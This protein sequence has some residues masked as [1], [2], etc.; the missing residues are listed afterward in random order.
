MEWIK[1]DA[2]INFIY[3]SIA[4]QTSVAD[5][6]SFFTAPD[7]AFPVPDPAFFNL[8]TTCVN[9]FLLQL[10]NCL[11][12]MVDRNEDYLRLMPNRV[13]LKFKYTFTLSSNRLIL[14]LSFLHFHCFLRI[15]FVFWKRIRIQKAMGNGMRMYLTRSAT[16]I[17]LFLML[18]ELSLLS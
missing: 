10:L 5:L 17:L 13:I 3:S 2:C 11:I 4:I 6:Y 1:R 8:Y 14:S 7:F 15:R 9:N 12:K 18:G 16:Q